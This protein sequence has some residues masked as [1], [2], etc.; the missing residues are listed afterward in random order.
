MT[1]VSEA[2]SLLK[3]IKREDEKWYFCHLKCVV[4]DRYFFR[5]IGAIFTIANELYDQL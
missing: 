5:K 3:N 1:S 4:K 2:N